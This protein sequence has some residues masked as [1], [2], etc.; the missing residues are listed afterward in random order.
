MAL[1]IA[2]GRFGQR[3]VTSISIVSAPACKGPVSSNRIRPLPE[4]SCRLSIDSPYNRDLMHFAKIEDCRIRRPLVR[5]LIAMSSDMLSLEKY[6]TPAS[7]ESVH[8]FN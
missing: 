3:F 6:W 2:D 7:V 8:E 1:S 5:L 4:R